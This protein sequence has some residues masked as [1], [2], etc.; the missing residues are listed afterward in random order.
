MKGMIKMKKMFLG[1]FCFVLIIIL[2]V[3][4]VWVE[5]LVNEVFVEKLIV[6]FLI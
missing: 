4:N 1:F 6:I 3:F 5:D 2:L